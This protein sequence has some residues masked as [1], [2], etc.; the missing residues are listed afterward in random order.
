MMNRAMVPKKI[1]MSFLFMTFLSMVASGKDRPT[2][3]IMNA[4]A[5]PNATPL[6]T[7][8]CTTGTIPTALAYIG[9]AS[10]TASGTAYQCSPLKCASKNPL[11]T[12]KY[13][14]QQCQNYYKAK[15]CRFISPAPPQHKSAIS[16]GVFATLWLHV[17]N[18]AHNTY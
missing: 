17:C 3:D 13:V 14:S 10:M 4:K 12:Q 9:T 15:N 8:T 2:T 6:A 18:V 16:N 7:K 1:P 5:V 11:G